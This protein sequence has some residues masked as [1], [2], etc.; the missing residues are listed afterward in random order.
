MSKSRPKTTYG[1]HGKVQLPALQQAPKPITETKASQEEIIE[2]KLKIHDMEAKK[3]VLRAGIARM[4]KTMKNRSEAIQRVMTTNQKE[5]SIKTASASTLQQLREE[6]ESLKNTIES[7]KAELENL[8]L[9]DK[10]QLSEEL[11]VEIQ[12]YYCEQL[13]LQEETQEAKRTESI[14]SNELNRIRKIIDS[15]QENEK[16]IDD[17]QNDIDNLTEKLFAYRKSELRIQN[18]KVMQDIVENTK[19]VDQVTSQL[20]EDIQKIQ[21]E[22]ENDKVEIDQIQENEVKNLEYLQEVIDKQTKEILKFINS[23]DQASNQTEVQP[24]ETLT[25]EEKTEQ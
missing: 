2:L 25:E 10:L 5:K 16:S 11:K 23:G 4:Q 14:I 24:D 7:R 6:A 8:K 12:I 13:R 9:C 15:T 1:F 19:T 22:I 17:L 20:R 3:R 21:Q 18:A